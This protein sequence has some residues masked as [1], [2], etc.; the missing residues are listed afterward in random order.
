MYLYCFDRLLSC[1]LSFG[2]KLKWH[3]CTKLPC[4]FRMPSLLPTLPSSEEYAFVVT[5]LFK[6]FCSFSKST[7]I[8][9]EI[10]SCVPWLYVNVRLMRREIVAWRLCK[11]P[12]SLFFFNVARDPTT[13]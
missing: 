5:F 6:V 13:R 9:K 8:Q 10:V 3:F 7:Q 11:S 2:L 1:V 4:I 12:F